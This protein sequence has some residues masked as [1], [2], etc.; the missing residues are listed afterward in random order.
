[1]KLKLKPFVLAALACSSSGQAASIPT[2]VINGNVDDRNTITALTNATIHLNADKTIEHATLLIQNDRILSIHAK[3]NH[4]ALTNAV[5]KDY[6]GMHIYPGFINLDSDVG[7]PEPNKREPF[8][9]GGPETINSTTKGAYN[10]NEAI[11]TSYDAAKHFSTDTKNNKKLRAA[12][13]TNAL[14]HRKDGIMRGTAVLSHLSDHPEELNMVVAKAAQHYSFDKGSSKQ[15]YPISLMGSVALIRQT[16]LDAQW[17]K[18]QNEMHDF[19][20]AAINANKSLPKIIN[21]TN[22]QQTLLAKTIADEF[23]TDF[24]VKT[25]GDSYQ[26]LAAIKASEQTL[27]VPLTKPKAP[28]INDELDAWNIS[29][30]DLKKWEVAPFNPALLEKE[31]IEFALVP[32]DSAKGL[33]TFLKDLRNAHQHGL[34]EKTALRAITAIPAKILNNSELGELNKGNF[35]NFVVTT[36]PLLAEDTLIAETWAAGEPYTIKGLPVMNAGHYQ[37]AYGNDLYEFNLMNEKGKL[38][39]AAI[40]EEDELKYSIKTAGNFATLSISGDEVNH[41]LFGMIDNR[42]F[43]AVDN[44]DWKLQKMGPVKNDKDAEQSKEK[45]NKDL[46]SIPSPFA[47]YG[48]LDIDDE[49]SVLIKNATVWTNEKDGI[50]TNTDVLVVNGKIKSIG[51]DL[52]IGKNGRKIDGTGMHLTSGIIDEHAH[53]ALLSVNDIAVNSSMVRM[54]DAINPHD[55]NIY[56]NLAGGVTA[57]Q[58]LHGSANPIGGQSALV[59]LKWGVDHPEDLLIEG[60][61]GFIKFA[62]GENVKRSRNQES[63]RYPLTRMGVEQVYRDAFTQALAYEKTW[64]DYNKLSSGAKKK[65]TAPRR[66]L[67]MEATLEVVNQER[68]ISCHSYVQSEINML[69]HVADDFGFNVNTFTH[70]LEGYKV[71][72]KMKAHGVGASTFSDWWAFK[73]EV[74]YAIPYNAALMHNAGVVTAINSDSAEMSRRLNQEAAKSIK[75]GGLSEEEAWKLVTLNPAKLLHLDDRMGSIKAGKDADLVLWS[76]N[77][78]SIYAKV[79]KTMV[80]GV[81]YYDRDKQAEIE[82]MIA[83]ERSRLITLSKNSKGPKAPFKTKPMKTYECESITGHHNIDQHFFTGAIK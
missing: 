20:L 37:L 42:E 83:D 76:E 57:A 66:D 72:D 23:G 38:K 14:S 34:S 47:A 51:S 35:A 80:D 68:M 11:K 7:L 2:D 17:Y 32:D 49:D 31:G 27:I 19:D 75:Y 24:V 15:D 55:V 61:T 52:S 25:S 13:F 45:N 46:P 12:G 50:L 30:R 16:W 8:K 69:M 59:K 5:V 64:T 79:V 77:P 81:V 65:T 33:D 36:G 56:R 73:W 18:Q 82:Q 62:L 74:N 22:W 10:S 39:L 53:I 70:I 60:A 58:L 26:N 41:D 71:A 28:K 78:L 54:K 63:I 67:V 44:G 29:Y 3:S 9:W 43:I 6:S 4:K 48:M 21:T 1:M 40:D